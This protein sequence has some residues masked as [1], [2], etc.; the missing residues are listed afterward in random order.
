MGDRICGKIDSGAVSKRI[1]RYKRL[2]GQ[3]TPGCRTKK[4]DARR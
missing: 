3:R 2:G 1:A 4:G